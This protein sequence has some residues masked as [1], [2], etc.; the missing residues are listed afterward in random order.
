MALSR[1]KI[2]FYVIANFNFLTVA[3]T[4]NLWKD[5]LGSVK[6][7]GGLSKQLEVQCQMHGV[8]QVWQSYFPR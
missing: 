1:A 2:G 6:A 8:K 3:E 5:I 4:G 7:S